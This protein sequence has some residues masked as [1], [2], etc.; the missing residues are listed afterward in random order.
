[1]HPGGTT[2]YATR[3]QDDV[4]DPDQQSVKNELEGLK[5][6]LADYRPKSELFAQRAAAE[7]ESERHDQRPTGPVE[8]ERRRIEKALRTGCRYRQALRSVPQREL[9]TA[10]PEETIQNRQR[11]RA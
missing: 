10:R 2:R 7:G 3:D 5:H 8:K 9:V 4:D 11:R 1:M 6:E